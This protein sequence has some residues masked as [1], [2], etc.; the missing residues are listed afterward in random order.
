MLQCYVIISVVLS[1]CR[2]PT[3]EFAH[4]VDLLC[5]YLTAFFLVDM[6]YIYN[7]LVALCV[8]QFAVSCKKDVPPHGGTTRHS[9][10]TVKDDKTERMFEDMF[11][12]IELIPL[13]NKR[14]CMVGN[15]MKVAVEGEHMYL[16]DMNGK[17]ALLSFNMDGSFHCKIG[18]MGHSKSEYANIYNFTVDR[19]GDT[20]V[21]LDYNALKLYD[22]DGGFIGLKD[23]DKSWDNMLLSTRG[24]VLGSHYRG[25]GMEHLIQIRDLRSDE[26]R[27]ILPVDSTVVSYPPYSKNMIQQV[28]DTVCF[29]DFLSSTFYLYDV[30]NPDDAESVQLHTDDMINPE[31]A[32]RSDPFGKVVN[33]L[34]ESYVYTGNEIIGLMS[35]DNQSS[36]FMVDVKK[37]EARCFNFSNGYCDFDCYHDGWFY[38]VL[39]SGWF[40]DMCKYSRVKG[41]KYKKAIELVG[42]GLT[43]QDNVVVMR[44]RMKR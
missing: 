36:S 18:D 44:V 19:D 1:L 14:E 15:C 28:G 27:D 20:I 12:D 30:H 17:D 10:L 7:I 23:L 32:K 41:E 37:K 22:M 25:L 8:V 21:L 29:F 4:S 9:V 5:F 35:K 39:S 42:K 3:L 2:V 40:L 31:I 13:E 26:V 34:V 24:L 16:W 6:K 38:T 43:E 11:C 33:D